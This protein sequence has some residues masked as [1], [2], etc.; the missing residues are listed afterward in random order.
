MYSSSIE[1]Y[2]ALADNQGKVL[3]FDTHELVT[4][5]GFT[6]AVCNLTVTATRTGTYYVIAEEDGHNGVGGYTVG[7]VEEEVQPGTQKKWTLDQV[8]HRLTDSGWAF[9]DGER[10]SWDKDAISYNDSSLEGKSAKLVAHAFD[11]WEKLTGLK[12]VKTTGAADI[13]FDDEDL[14]KAYASSELK[15]NGAMKSSTINIGKDWDAGTGTLDSYLFQTLIH[16][17]G[18]AVGLAHA[19]D[20]NAGQ[21][22]PTAYPDSVLFLNDSWNTTI[23]SYI[24]QDMN[25]NDN[26]DRALIMTPMIAD[27]IA[28]QDLYGVPL[29]AYDGNTRYGVNSNTG[30]YM[31]LVFDALCKGDFSSNLIAG[32]QT[33]S[34]TLWDTGGSDTIDFST[35]INAQRVNLG[36]T[37][38]SDIYGVR[39]SMVIGR[40]AVIENYIA[41]TKNDVVIG[42][43]ANNTIDGRNGND[44]LE[45]GSGNDRLLGGKGGDKLTGDKGNDVLKGGSQADTFA[46]TQGS[47]KDTVLDF[48]ND[49]DRV[50]LDNNLWTGNLTEQQIIDQFGSK[51]GG[52]VIFDFGGGDVLTLNNV[53]LNALL[54]DLVIV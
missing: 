8:A 51:S 29:K 27:I 13:V 41:G 12:F 48:Q 24:N 34:F 6:Y 10:R 54:D 26:A 28:I 5:L 47:D 20:Y 45:G 33:L 3:T 22:G 44:A 1:S 2:L 18:H 40:D 49:L 17:I 14:G 42:N 43:G 37:K 23:M 25:T 16:E 31:D 53:T 39:G 19:G 7:V 32:G 38:L 52:N 11:A 35:D 50:R 15:A 21:G 30:D 36:Q 46:F 4:Y 9:F